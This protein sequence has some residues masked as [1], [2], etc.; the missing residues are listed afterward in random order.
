MFRI[1]AKVSILDIGD[2]GRDVVGLIHGEPVKTGRNGGAQHGGTYQ[3]NHAK[4]E[5]AELAQS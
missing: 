2:T 4:S 1:D 5:E 3:H